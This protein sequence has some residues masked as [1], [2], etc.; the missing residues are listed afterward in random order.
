MERID[1][2]GIERNRHGGLWIGLIFL[3]I[4]LGWLLRQVSFPFPHWIFGW[5]MILIIV[6][7]VIGIKNKFRDAAWAIMILIGGIFLVRDIFPFLAFSNYFW[8][9]ALIVL[10]V[11]LIVRPRK[12]YWNRYPDPN[13][14]YGEGNDPITAE[15]HLDFTAAFGG[16]KKNILTKNFRGGDVTCIFGGTELNF[17]QADIQGTVTLDVTQIFGGTKLIVPSNWDIKSDMTAIFG[18]IDD[19]RSP[20]PNVDHAK[21]LVVDGT[22][23]FGGIEILSY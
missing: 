18:G 13:A 16:L 5:E 7:L 15:D 9:I 11:F 4:G 14:A 23:I 12:R 22:S 2:K 8:P 20:S 17:M 19:K 21:V 6:G 1:K 10:G 3:L